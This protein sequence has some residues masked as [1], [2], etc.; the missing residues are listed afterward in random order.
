MCT[1]QAVRGAKKQSIAREE[2]IYKKKNM[3]MI[4]INIFIFIHFFFIELGSAQ[5]EVPL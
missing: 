1:V 2:T 4:I 5:P 3:T